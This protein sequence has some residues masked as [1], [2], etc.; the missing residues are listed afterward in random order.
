MGYNSHGKKHGDELYTHIKKLED[1][2]KKIKAA[3]KKISDDIE[4]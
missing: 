2:I 1:N 4:P 3:L